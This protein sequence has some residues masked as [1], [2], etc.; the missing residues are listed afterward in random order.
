M[1]TRL[2]GWL[3]VVAVCGCAGLRLAQPAQSPEEAF[4]ARWTGRAEDDV[5]LHYGSPT[6]QITL[7]NGNL[8]DSYHNETNYSASSG[9]VYGNVGGASSRSQTIFCDRRF[10]ID[11]TT[12]RVV[13]VAIVGTACDY[14][15]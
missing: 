5:I 6:E 4:A 14:E 10:E 3:V 9:M 11:K 7:G 12:G 1:S 15:L 8:V 2:I 13:R